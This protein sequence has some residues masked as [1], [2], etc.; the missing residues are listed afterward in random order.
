MPS[1]YASILRL[2]RDT[3][4]VVLGKYGQYVVTIITVP[5]CAHTLGVSGTGLLAI[6]ASAY[7][8]GSVAVDFGLSQMLASRAARSE[9]TNELRLAFLILRLIIL[10]FLFTLLLFIL[11]VRAPES[12][13]LIFLGLFIG[14]LSS[15]GEEWI[16]TGRGMFGRIV[17][18]QM[19]GRIFYLLSLL[20]ALSL[21][22][23]PGIVMV[24]L[25]LSTS[26]SSILSWRK[27]GVVAWQR[28]S[29]HA[30]GRLLW[31]GL[32]S[33]LGRTLTTSYGQG[34]AL[35][36]ASVV[37]AHG[38]GLF[39]AG[40]K[41]VRA[42]Q[43]ALDAFG[44]ALLPRIAS[45]DGN[46]YSASKW[47]RAYY[48]AA[49]GFVLGLMA[50]VA[51]W[52]LAPWV[53]RVVYGAD[54]LEAV[55]MMRFE[56]LVL[57]AAA[58]VSTVITAVLY[59]YEDSRGVLYT[60]VVGLTGTVVGVSLVLYSNNFKIMLV[61]V[62]CSEWGAAVFVTFRMVYLRRIDLKKKNLVVQP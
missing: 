26:L 3:V 19:I 48:G 18:Y 24:C 1:R 5:L 22:P 56:A 12:V 58:Y 2:F 46:Q 7:F 8:F 53:I 4:Y 47:G 49:V 50:A 32:P 6:A 9:E 36:Y 23:S 60:A 44:A 31:L 54:F 57:P 15:T 33:V 27:V 28:P 59:V 61:G 41:F 29:R 35:I 42:A 62:F 16:L 13:V 43:S 11:A 52:F 40:D 17:T 34:A 37:P 45:T 20:I 39:S 10:F 55:S 38:L 30:I 14:G 25:G 21:A 51:L